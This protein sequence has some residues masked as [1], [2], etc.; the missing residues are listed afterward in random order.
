M[1]S[2]GTLTDAGIL[3]GGRV[4]FV[5]YSAIAMRYSKIN[6]GFIV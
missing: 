3:S 5:T 6:E 4:V 1:H 2:L